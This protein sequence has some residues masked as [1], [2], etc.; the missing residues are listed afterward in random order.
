MN[1]RFLFYLPFTL[2]FLFA[3]QKSCNIQQAKQEIMQTENDFASA[4]SRQGV[5]AAFLAYAADSAVIN[6]SN[7]IIKGKQDIR[8][9]FD[10]QVYTQIQLRW[11]PDVVDVSTSCDLGY[12]YGKYTLSATD[13][14]GKRIEWYFSHRLETASRWAMAICLR[15]KLNTRGPNEQL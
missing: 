7:R 11:E 15:L 2:L 12:T 8:A 1:K 13:T 14:T 5:Q 10:N 9:Y 6:R 4:A 3:C